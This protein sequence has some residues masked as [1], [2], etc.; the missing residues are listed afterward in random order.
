[1]IL[2]S[3]S[4]ISGQR[5]KSSIKPDKGKRTI[6]TAIIDIHPFPE[7]KVKLDNIELK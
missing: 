3:L 4:L 2:D 7:I 5:T 6:I 1:M